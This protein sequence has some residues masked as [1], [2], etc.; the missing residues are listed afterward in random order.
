MTA[1]ARRFEYWTLDPWTPP[2]GGLLALR[3][4]R[5][6]ADP[7]DSA[8]DHAR[9]LRARSKGDPGTRYALVEAV[10][11]DGE[12][13]EVLLRA[14]FISGEPAGP[15]I[16]RNLARGPHPRRQSPHRRRGPYYSLTLA[17]V[18][19]EAGGERA[20]RAAGGT[21]ESAYRTLQRA[22]A[23]LAARKGE[24]YDEVEEVD[25]TALMDWADAR[26]PSK[27]EPEC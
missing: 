6:A 4:T 21:A 26:F 18:V 22:H 16:A 2:A 13:E 25:G 20:L 27:E 3:W 23:A 24:A 19:R 7:A 17:E 10:R 11:R 15:G 9:L 1:P 14:L 5:E 8:A 12:P